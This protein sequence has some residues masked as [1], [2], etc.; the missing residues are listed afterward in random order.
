MCITLI[1]DKRYILALTG[2]SWRYTSRYLFTRKSKRM[3]SEQRLHPFKNYPK[4]GAF[5]GS[6]VANISGSRYSGRGVRYRQNSN[7]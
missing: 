2:T 5:D 3:A 7:D 6:D 1:D 4:G